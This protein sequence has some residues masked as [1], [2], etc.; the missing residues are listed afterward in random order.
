[1]LR[2]LNIPI[3][4]F[5]KY[6]W[7]AGPVHHRNDATPLIL[8]KMTPQPPCLNINVRS[9]LRVTYANHYAGNVITNT[10]CLQ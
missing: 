10:F 2:Y 3:A 9:S 1:M 4:L 6:I 8:S 7:R 5:K